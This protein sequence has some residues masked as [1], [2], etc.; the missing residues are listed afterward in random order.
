MKKES[1][2]LIFLICLFLFIFTL[3]GMM[4]YSTSISNTLLIFKNAGKLFLIAMII[5]GIF[6]LIGGIGGNEK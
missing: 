4:I 5:T 2:Q 1:K 3:I 6:Y